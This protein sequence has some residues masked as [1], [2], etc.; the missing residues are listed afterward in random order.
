MLNAHLQSSS[1]TIKSGRFLRSTMDMSSNASASLFAST[2]TEPLFIWLL[3]FDCSVFLFNVFLYI[4]RSAP[5]SPCWI[6]DVS[7]RNMMPMK[8][9][10][11]THVRRCKCGFLYPD[12][13]WYR[14]RPPSFLQYFRFGHSLTTY[15]MSFPFAFFLISMQMKG[16]RAKTT[17]L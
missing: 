8:L 3:I 7:A 15:S 17:S 14:M 6:K 16:A 2:N 9:T 1:F 4:S 12:L 11:A 13:F 10:F 5:S